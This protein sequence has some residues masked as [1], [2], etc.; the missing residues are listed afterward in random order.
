MTDGIDLSDAV[1]EIPLLQDD[2]TY[3]LL[4]PGSRFKI[5]IDYDVK[6]LDVNMPG[7]YVVTNNVITSEKTW[8]AQAG[9]ATDFHLNLGMTTVKFD[10]TVT[11]WNTPADKVEVDLPNNTLEVIP[12]NAPANT[13]TN[14]PHYITNSFIGE[15]KV[16]PAGEDGKYYYNTESKKLFQYRGDPAHWDEVGEEYYIANSKLYYTN[17]VPAIAPRWIWVSNVPYLLTD[18]KYVNKTYYETTYPSVEALA[19]ANPE[20]GIYV[21]GT[22]AADSK[23]YYYVKQY[24]P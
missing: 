20:T 24:N 10:A 2:A 5:V 19:K 14:V 1:K 3:A 22:T 17:R 15:S 11:N 12:A 16:V 7:N 9:V 8:T 4:I 23:Y 21:V 13:L 6:T 18:G